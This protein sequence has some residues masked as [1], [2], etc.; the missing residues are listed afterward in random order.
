[1]ESDGHV[2]HKYI[3]ADLAGLPGELVERL[4]YISENHFGP[5]SN[6][7]AVKAIR[8]ILAWDRMQKGGGE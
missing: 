6:H 4:R 2:Y 5:R 8:D 1:M 3:R 7:T